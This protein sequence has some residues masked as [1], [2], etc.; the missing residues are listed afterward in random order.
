[1]VKGFGFGGFGGVLSVGLSKTVVG[2]DR[3]QVEEAEEE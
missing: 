3:R 2:T 1:M